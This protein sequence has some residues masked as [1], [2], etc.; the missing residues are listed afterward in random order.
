VVILGSGLTAATGFLFH[1]PQRRLHVTLTVMMAALMGLFV[2][3]IVAMDNPFRGEMGI[4][5]DAFVLVFKGL[6][7]G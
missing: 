2:F 3:L 1:V 5:P 7:G 6:M 4:G